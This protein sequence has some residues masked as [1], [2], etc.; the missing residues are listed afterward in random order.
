VLGDPPFSPDSA[1]EK[2]S[3]A[4]SVRSLASMTP[5]STCRSWTLRHRNFQARSLIARQKEHSEDEWRCSLRGTFCT[6]DGPD[7]QQIG[8]KMARLSALLAS[9]WIFRELPRAAEKRNAQLRFRCAVL[10]VHHIS[11]LGNRGRERLY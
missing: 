2:C 6:H 7:Y 11:R 10:D 1:R 9:T 8:V 3:V 4:Q 5:T